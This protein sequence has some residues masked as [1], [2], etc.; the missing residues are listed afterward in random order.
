M[1]ENLIGF[2]SKKNILAHLLY[3][4]PSS[5]LYALPIL[6][7]NFHMGVGADGNYY[8]GGTLQN[9]GD[10]DIK[11]A[12]IDYV[13][14]SARCKAGDGGSYSIGPILKGEKKP[15]KIPVNGQM[16]SYKIIG[17]SGSDYYG[18]PVEIKDLTFVAMQEKNKKE[19]MLCIN[20]E[21]G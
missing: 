10:E 6:Q 20:N 5:F 13:V 12:F 4:L 19:R 2:F 18:F 9:V 7:M 1:L 16:V 15:F 3:F 21:G 17:F 11:T 8:I 14:N